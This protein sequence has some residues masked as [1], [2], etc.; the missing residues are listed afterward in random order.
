MHNLVLTQTAA[1]G[2]APACPDGPPC[3]PACLRLVSV[4]RNVF[5]DRATSSAVP[6][7]RRN[8]V[9]YAMDRRNLE[10]KTMPR[11]LMLA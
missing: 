11:A 1:R 8:V 10:R 3:L 5:T 7:C 2:Y 6:P 9:T 4:S